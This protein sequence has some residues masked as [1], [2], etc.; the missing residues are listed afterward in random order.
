MSNPTQ[1]KSTNGGGSANGGA[2]PMLCRTCGFS[3]SVRKRRRI[4]E[5]LCPSCGAVTFLVPPIPRPPTSFPRPKINV[6]DTC[7]VDDDTRSFCSDHIDFACCVDGI[8]SPDRKFENRNTSD[9]KL[10]RGDSGSLS[11]RSRPVHQELPRE[12]KPRSH[13]RRQYLFTGFLCVQGALLIYAFFLLFDAVKSHNEN[14]EIASNTQIVRNENNGEIGEMALKPAVQKDIATKKTKTSSKPTDT[15]VSTQGSQ[16]ST[17]V[18]EKNGDNKDV[19]EEVGLSDSSCSQFI[20]KYNDASNVEFARDRLPAEIPPSPFAAANSTLSPE[21]ATQMPS[22]STRKTEKL[23]EETQESHWVAFGMDAMNPPSPDASAGKTITPQ[24]VEREMQP[25]SELPEILPLPFYSSQNSHAL[26]PESLTRNETQERQLTPLLHPGSVSDPVAHA[27]PAVPPQHPATL[28]SSENLSAKSM[29]NPEGRESEI[30]QP[31]IPQEVVDYQT[32]LR[33]TEALLTDARNVLERD[34]ARSLDLAVE[35]AKNYHQLGQ[36]IP[37]VLHGILS[38]ALATQCWGESLVHSFPAVE[39]MAIT[40]DGCWLLTGSVDGAVRL[41]DLSQY[42]GENSGYL[43]DHADSRLVKLL[44]TPDMCWAIGGTRK[45]TIHLWNTRHDHPSRERIDLEAA[46]VGL[47][48]LEM[49]PDGR[50]LIAYGGENEAQSTQ[51][52]QNSY[53]TQNVAVAP[54]KR[55]TPFDLADGEI[56]RK[57][58]EQPPA[59]EPTRTAESRDAC[60][61]R[62]WEVDRLLDGDRQPIILRGHEKPIR[63]VT[64]SRDSRWLVTGSEDGTARVFD[65]QSR[66]PGLEQRVLKGHTAAIT[67]IVVAADHS[68]IAT[69]GRDNTVRLWSLADETGF[70]ESRLLTGHLGWVDAL[71]VSPNGRWLASASYDK[72]VRLWDMHSHPSGANTVPR[73][74]IL[75]TRQG[76]LQG[77]RFS[78]D[79]RTLISQGVDSSL[80]LWEIR[81]SAVPETPVGEIAVSIRDASVSISDF[82]LTGDN[83]WLILS[84]CALDGARRGGIRLWPLQ[85]EGTLNFADELVRAQKNSRSG[86]P[87]LRQQT[88]S[89]D[90]PL[91]R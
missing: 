85:F 41:W 4:T 55:S 82:V 43:L 53:S 47:R 52:A 29:K 38:Q 64:V 45:G 3:F 30:S 6:D 10:K 5:V 74:L 24:T 16:K 12:S 51:S 15:S 63:T 50:W 14:K 60:V 88:H 7:G 54:K 23:V 11:E 58:R 18:C 8:V 26:I 91:V 83:R 42:R 19:G 25:S 79:G 89:V 75:P 49:T 57:K 37:S 86:E 78:R 22:A 87:P 67:S 36:A 72:T 35:A 27:P 65:L 21:A 81:D 76:A 66:S 61:V 56:F 71:A 90:R 17:G 70:P 77:V 68:W 48:G 20:D 9:G 62:L 80:C 34:P 39:T 84:Y 1:E 31:A 28:P 33:L 69:G 2:S 40:E 73:C 13:G 32:R 59:V 44:F 46:V